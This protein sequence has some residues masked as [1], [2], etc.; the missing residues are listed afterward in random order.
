MILKD[1]DTLNRLLSELEAYSYHKK[2]QAL[3]RNNKFRKV[4]KI[5]RAKISKFYSFVASLLSAKLKASVKDKEA[6]GG[7][8]EL[9]QP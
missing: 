1:F 9:N 2:I 4:Q 6:K 5:C 3:E 8:P 7:K